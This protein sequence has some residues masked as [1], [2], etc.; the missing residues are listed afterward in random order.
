MKSIGTA[1]YVASLLI[2]QQASQ[3]NYIF[4]PAITT[5]GW[6]TDGTYMHGRFEQL[7]G[8]RGDWDHSNSNGSSFETARCVSSC[9]ITTRLNS[10]ESQWCKMIGVKQTGLQKTN[11]DKLEQF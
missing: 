6:W 8:M 10:Y 4:L 3:I 9:F 7:A 2:V 5:E 11:L 1:D